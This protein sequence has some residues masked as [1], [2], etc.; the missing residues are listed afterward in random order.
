MSFMWQ[1]MALRYIKSYLITFK[2]FAILIFA[3]KATIGISR[4]EFYEA[5]A[6]YVLAAFNLVNKYCD[7]TTDTPVSAK[8]PASLIKYATLP[9]VF[10]VNFRISMLPLFSD[11]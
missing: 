8:F 9:R 1:L 10:A 5:A 2:N 3:I 11:Y 7:L 4:T 6:P